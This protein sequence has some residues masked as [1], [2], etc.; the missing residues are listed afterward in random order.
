MVMDS[1]CFGSDIRFALKPSCLQ[2]LTMEWTLPNV[3][4]IHTSPLALA[5]EVSAITGLVGR[6]CVGRNG[7][8]LIGRADQ[9]LLSTE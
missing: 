9:R 5:G 6:N 8:G 7:G 1:S 3:S 2:A 4:S